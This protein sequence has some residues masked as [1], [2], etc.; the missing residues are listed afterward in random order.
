MH[1]FDEGIVK[2]YLVRLFGALEMDA[3]E[4]QRV[5][6]QLALLASTLRKAGSTVEPPATLTDD[7][8]TGEKLRLTGA[9]ACLRV[10]ICCSHCSLH[11]L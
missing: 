3:A 7:E 5:R 9:R 1:D 2:W 11:A 8:L 10:S 6:A 4:R